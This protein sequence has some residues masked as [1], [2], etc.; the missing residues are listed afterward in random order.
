M[1]SPRGRSGGGGAPLPSQNHRWLAHLA[2]SPVRPSISFETL[3]NGREA[4]RYGGHEPAKS[5]LGTGA[6]SWSSGG[7]DRRRFGNASLE[8]N[9]PSWDG[10]GWLAGGWLLPHRCARGLAHSWTLDLGRLAT[11]RW[12]ALDLSW[13]FHQVYSCMAQACMQAGGSE[14]R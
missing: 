6:R 14:N 12:K 3:L 10:S 13:N 2:A 9:L 7:G 4:G 11:H 8:N 1:S 5:A